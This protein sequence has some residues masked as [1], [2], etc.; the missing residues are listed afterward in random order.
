[1][2]TPTF[3]PGHYHAGGWD[4]DNDGTI[5]MTVPE[6]MRSMVQKRPRG[7]EVKTLNQYTG[8]FTSDE[9]DYP[10]SVVAN[11]IKE[12]AK[13]LTMPGVFGA[14]SAEPTMIKFV[15][16]SIAVSVPVHQVGFN[17]IITPD[18]AVD[19]G[20]TATPVHAEVQNGTDVIFTATEPFGWNFVAWYKGDPDNG[21]TQI[22]TSKVTTID[23]YDAYS[24]LVDYY[25]KYEFNPVIRN[26]RYMDVSKGWVWDFDFDGY[27][28]YKGR[29]VLTGPTTGDYYFVISDLT[30]D[31]NG[32]SSTA[33]IIA[34]PSITQANDISMSIT[35][36]PTYIGLEIIIVNATASNLLGF[37][38]D[39]VYELK[40]VGTSRF[41]GASKVVTQ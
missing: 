30:I 38:K 16:S 25:A 3:V 10:V 28:N 19:A 12:A 13:I 22:S 18:E 6:A 31:E 24:T 8:Y 33:T 36:S 1:M 2:A 41:E 39:K 4:I 35:F 9:G 15:K 26:G 23:V 11:S 20:A 21:G 17:T 14:D 27:S 7:Q 29:L 5:D 34:D 40:Y 37:E 32:G